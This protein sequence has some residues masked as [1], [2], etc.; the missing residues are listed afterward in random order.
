MNELSPNAVKID[1]RF[2]NAKMKANAATSIFHQWEMLE[3]TGC[4]DNFRIA[5]GEKQGFRVGWFF[6]DSD[7]TKW[8]DAASRILRDQYNHKLCLLM[9]DF[10]ALLGRAQMDD[11]YLFT[12]NQVHFPGQ[13][14][15]NL[16]VEH[17]LYCHGHLIEAGVS[18]Y[19][20]T[21]R[22]DLLNI[23]R[24]AADLLVRD[25][26]HAGPQGTPGHE[27]IEI[28]LLRLYEVTQH[29]PYRELAL[30]FLEQ[31][32]RTPFFGVSLVKQF[33]NNARREKLIAEKRKA[34]ETAHPGVAVP[35]VPAMN[36]AKR[37]PFSL[38]R[39]YLSGLNGKYF[40]QHLPV[41]EQTVP[42][43]H[44]VRF[45]YLETAE[46]MFLH[47]HK[48]DEL[49]ATMTH[50]WEHMVTRRMD[51]T[52]GLGALPDSEGF[53]RDYELNPEIAYNET[54]A[55]IS[56][57]YWNWQL[58]NLT[59]QAKYSD[60]LE[61]QLYN[62][63]SV[64][65]DTRGASYFY[66]NPTLSRSGLSRQPWYSIPCCPSN[67]SRTY[68]DL[69][70]YVFSYDNANLWI[71]QYIGSQAKLDADGTVGASI[72]SALPIHGDIK[73]TISTK[74]PHSFIL[75]LRRPSWAGAFSV[76]MDGKMLD[77]D[78]HAALKSE[79]TASGYDP[80]LSL[81]I[82]IEGQ[83]QGK[84][85]IVVRAEL[86][87]R[88]LHPH[89]KVRALH[90]KAGVCR[91]PL[92]YCLES[93]DN[94]EVDIFESVIMVDSLAYEERPGFLDGSGVIRGRTTNGQAVTFISYALWGNREPSAMTVWVRFDK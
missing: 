71:H 20:A 66:N 4:I 17:E 6:A 40:Q 91:G 11:G 49:L 83:W 62:A 67:I 63:V 5:A 77:Y 2:W 85:E 33:I 65:V 19:Q 80:R 84:T 22:N 21:G 76:M 35:N 44:S 88:V 64:G 28:A 93:T 69:G 90:G 55:A 92:V 43:G 52:G 45:G 61:W 23:S 79:A 30:H 42:V 41:R 72:E 14:W 3:A 39:F 32:G 68:A 12:Y 15:V 10:I 26:L 87:I 9:D 37:P 46:A 78:E 74:D 51:V 13:R 57:L 1:D 82:P 75:W 70:R 73:I 16:Q 47:R 25:F 56:S 89:S 36:K 8:L 53:G 94:P 29:E 50:A 81:F 34:Y 86:P 54:C 58:A 59:G 60:L 24:K 31:R 18:H 27:E 38:M 48:D 7:A